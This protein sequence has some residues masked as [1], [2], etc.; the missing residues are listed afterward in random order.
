MNHATIN[1]KLITLL[2]GALILFAFTSVFSLL[3]VKLDFM[4]LKLWKEIAIIGCYVVC[5]TAFFFKGRYNKKVF[6]FSI[7]LPV[8]VII[9]YLLTSLDDNRTLVFYK[10]KSDIVPFLFPLAFICLIGNDIQATNIYKKICKILVGVGIINCF[11]IFIQR[12]FSSW[13]L[14]LLQIDDMNN[15]QGAS[16]LRLDNVHSGLRAMGSMTSFINSGTLMILCIFIILESGYYNRFKKTLYLPLF[17]VAAVMTTYKTAMVALA[18]YIPLKIVLLFLRGEI[19]KKL[20]IMFCTFISFTLMA[21]VFNT[22][23]LYDKMKNTALKEEAYN[24][25]YLRVV[26]HKDIFND[27]ANASILTG[28]GIGVNGTTGPEQEKIKYRSKPLD[29]QY[30]SLLSNYGMLGVVVYLLIFIA[31]MVKCTF[32]NCLGGMLSCFLIFYHVG[33]EFFAN[34]MLPN[35]PI[36]V[37]FS[38]LICFSLFYKEK[39]EQDKLVCS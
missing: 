7:V 37:Y 9:I 24:S 18:I 32:R 20:V 28:V 30:I 13:F 19:N 25:I 29:S 17:V 15:K 31:V 3:A 26:Q 12:M 21:T 38:V 33:V 27:V 8:Y 6:L 5:I 39:Y 34:N 16:G 22:M 14:I 1:T 2:Y 36:N 35:F 23:Y 11:L 10:M 4:I